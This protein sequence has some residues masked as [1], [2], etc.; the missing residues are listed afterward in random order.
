MTSKSKESYSQLVK[1]LPSLDKDKLC[2]AISSKTNVPIDHVYAIVNLLLDEIQRELKNSRSIRI[3]NFGRF[4]LIQPKP[5][6]IVNISTGAHEV[7]ERKRRLKFVLDRAFSS[8]ISKFIEM[9]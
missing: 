9:E 4:E 5:K 7:V 3:V 8:F 1:K 2:K 6:K